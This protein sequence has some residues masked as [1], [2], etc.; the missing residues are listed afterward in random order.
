MARH[1]VCTGLFK[2]M[3]SNSSNWRAFGFL[4]RNPATDLISTATRGLIQK[5]GLNRTVHRLFLFN[6]L[7]L[8]A[9]EPGCE[10]AHMRAPVCVW[11]GEICGGNIVI[12]FIDCLPVSSK[13]LE[14]PGPSN[15]TGNLALRKQFIHL[16]IPPFYFCR[17]RKSNGVTKI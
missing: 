5:M 4:V 14:I 12:D 16:F 2:E 13:T 9:L 8:F 15:L 7:S 6:P 17:Y 1:V 10:H 3:L 11:Q